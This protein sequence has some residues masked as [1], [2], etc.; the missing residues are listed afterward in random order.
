MKITEEAKWKIEFEKQINNPAPKKWKS[1]E[2]KKKW[3]DQFWKDSKWSKLFIK[4]VVIITVVLFGY[5][6]FSSLDNQKS[7]K[8]KIPGNMELSE[9]MEKMAAMPR[10][11]VNE[12]KS[13]NKE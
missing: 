3:L 8:Q 9:F 4:G 10:K 13:R 1:K 6:N 11:I 5:F 12:L 7:L 2:K